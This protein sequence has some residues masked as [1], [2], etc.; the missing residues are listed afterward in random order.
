MEK[1]PTALVI[2][3]GFGHREDKSY[4]AVAHAQTPTLDRL[5]ESCPHTLLQASGTAVGL[6]EGYIGNSEVGH[7]TIGAGRIITQPISRLNDM[8]DDES[9]FASD[10]LRSCLRKAKD[11]SGRVHIMGLLS[12]GG[13]HS[14]ERHIHAFVQAAAQEG[15]KEIY[16]H[17]FLDGRDTAPQRATTY[18][19]RLEDVL[20]QYGGVIGSLHGRYYAM[21]RD[22]HWDRTKISYDV[23][24]TPHEQAP[25][26]WVTALSVSYER[27]ETDEFFYPILLDEHAVIRDGDGVIFANVRPDRA[28]QLTAAFVQPDFDHFSRKQ[29][30]LSFFL[31]PVA[32]DHYEG[33]AVLFEH[34]HVADTLIDCLVAAGKSI[35]AIAETEKYAH[36]TYFFS[37][38][39]EEPVAGETRVLIPSI[40]VPTYVEHPCMSAPEITK[41]VLESLKTAPCD[42]YLINYANADMV[43]HSGD[44]DATVKAVECLDG[45]I[46]QLYE[47]LV[48]KMDGTIYITADHGNAEQMFDEMR[49]MPHT[50][51][52]TNPVPFI[53]CS[54]GQCDGEHPVPALKELADIAPYILAHMGLPVP[55]TMK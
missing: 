42:F 45:Q 36:V 28:R 35:F 40:P 27:D 25:V 31:S 55:E 41:R 12:D 20:K 33:V 48:E 51:H 14:H 49:N 16:V 54:K 44:F 5:M 37:G 39:R 29:L 38:G 4:N 17:P 15:I 9:F 7:M 23:L 1:K 43:G 22:H 53:V 13:V 3:D 2:L 24:T 18:L 50:A 8:I 10:A 32:Y 34:T 6:P 47:Q 19:E 30:A 11:A 46:K 52:T 26:S 21:D